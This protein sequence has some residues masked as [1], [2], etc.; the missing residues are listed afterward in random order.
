MDSTLVKRLVAEA[1]GAMN[2]VTAVDA[3]CTKTSAELLMDEL[4]I[5]GLEIRQR[6]KPGRGGR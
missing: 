6:Q 3:G 5:R 4:E 2:G 1:L